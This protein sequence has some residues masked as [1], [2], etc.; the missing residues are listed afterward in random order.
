MARMQGTQVQL[1]NYRDEHLRFAERDAEALIRTRTEFRNAYRTM[2]RC[3]WDAAFYAKD[4][5]LRSTSI[6]AN[7]PRLERTMERYAGGIK[8]LDAV[9]VDC[10]AIA[11]K[12]DARVVSRVPCAG[13]GP[14]L[15]PDH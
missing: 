2:L 5:P 3:E 8:R 9:V 6:G 12:A 13:A 10:L 11:R 14:R 1:R 15:D 4:H 7:V